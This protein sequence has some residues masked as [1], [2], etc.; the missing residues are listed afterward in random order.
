LSG[1]PIID[2]K[3]A[4]IGVISTARDGG[5]FNLGPSLTHFNLGPSLTDCLPAHLLRKLRPEI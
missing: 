1:S 3:G 4:A 2:D 5:D